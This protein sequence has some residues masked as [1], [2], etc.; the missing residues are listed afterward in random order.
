MRNFYGLC[1]LADSDEIWQD[2]ISYV[3]VSDLY[4][5]TGNYTYFRKR[6]HF[7]TIFDKMKSRLLSKIA[8]LFA[9]FLPGLISCTPEEAA[10][11]L[12]VNINQLN[13][14]GEGKSFTLSVKSN[15]QIYVKSSAEWCMATVKHDPAKSETGSLMIVVDATD[16]KME[17]TAS[18]T[19]T[20]E[21]CQP[22]VIRVIQDHVIL[23]TEKSLTSLSL[24][25]ADNPALKNDVDFTY[26]PHSRTFSAIY[27]KC[28][29]GSGCVGSMR[30]AFE[31]AVIGFFQRYFY[32]FY[33]LSLSVLYTT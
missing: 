1:N 23:S 3:R 32:A 5:D 10:S 7:K 27:L 6:L 26:D 16:Q 29:I 4:G 22:A 13:V 14:P 31:Y 24:K 15:K 28:S 19:L 21:S 20:A 8:V 2:S 11:Y 30:V 12:E 25:K 33:A 18:V 9:M 17:R